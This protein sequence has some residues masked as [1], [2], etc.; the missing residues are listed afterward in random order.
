MGRR[1]SPAT[2]L[3]QIARDRAVRERRPSPREEFWAAT[4]NYLA[5]TE[6]PQKRAQR[7]REQLDDAEQQE[8][9]ELLAAAAQ[10][11]VDAICAGWD[12]PPWS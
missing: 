4:E 10:S 7:A 3:A 2:T 8:V 6:D 9:A 5:A 1:V 11:E 12:K